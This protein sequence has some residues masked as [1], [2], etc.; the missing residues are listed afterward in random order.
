MTKLDLTMQSASIPV[1]KAGAA[2]AHKM[3]AQNG[4]AAL[5]FIEVMAGEDKQPE[6]KGQNENV[7]HSP[8]LKQVVDLQQNE[9]PKELI[10]IDVDQNFGGDDDVDGE[11]EV[12]TIKDNTPKKH[13]KLAIPDEKK[14]PIEIQSSVTNL[15]ANLSAD[16]KSDPIPQN[17]EKVTSDKSALPRMNQIDI[18]PI[19]HS[20]LLDIVSGDEKP[21]VVQSQ[22]IAEDNPEVKVADK[23]HSIE[24]ANLL[25]TKDKRTPLVTEKIAI[26]ISKTETHFFI[27]TAN[28]MAPQMAAKIVDQLNGG[29]PQSTSATYKTPLDNRPNLVKSLHIQLIPESLGELN[30]VMR[31]RGTELILKVE[32][33][34]KMAA[35]KLTEDKDLLEDLLKKAGFDLADNA[36]TI[37]V[38]SDHS[39]ASTN[40]SNGPTF[41][42][43]PNPDNSSAYFGN[44]FGERHEKEQDQN[45]SQKGEASSSGRIAAGKNKGD[46]N[47]GVNSSAVSSSNLYI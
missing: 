10:P 44:P 7:H 45:R 26:S 20:H 31:L 46:G 16:R 35:V 8:R 15:L 6:P 38:R 25:S 34:S 32:A 27:D 18:L 14:L 36:L 11:I 13:D 2:F 28:A 12:E 29:G 33:A 19:K 21:I 40:Q 37:I 17:N 9:N 24:T 3:K 39:M 23:H 30:I 1:G 4:K 43:R 41:G 47:A 5:E 42:D 22:K